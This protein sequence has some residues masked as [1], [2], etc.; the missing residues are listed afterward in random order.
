MITASSIAGSATSDSVI[1]RAAL[2][3]SAR[4]SRSATGA[5]LCEMP[6]TTS[7]EGWPLRPCCDS[8]VALLRALSL[9]AC[10]LLLC[11]LVEL[12]ELAL[13]AR[14][15]RAHDAEVDHDHR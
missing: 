5:V 6:R 1:V 12:D 10:Q 4:R 15:A 14:Q 3:V 8:P 11:Q 9:I 13:Q 7:S 2:S